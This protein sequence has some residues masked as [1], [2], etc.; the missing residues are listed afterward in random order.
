[1]A[2]QNIDIELPEDVAQG[3]YANLAMIAHSPAE[4][5]ID[6]IQ[7]LPGMPKGR[8]RS[9]LI[10]TP[11]HAK[12]LLAALEDNLRKYE[13]RFGKIH[14]QEMHQPPFSGPVGEA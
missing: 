6:F 5:V 7:I 4:F 14:V 11:E 13:A 12:R 1:M 9:R 10:L 8:V 2:S 3:V